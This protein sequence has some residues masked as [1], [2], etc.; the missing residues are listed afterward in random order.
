MGEGRG[1]TTTKTAVKRPPSRIAVREREP[2]QPAIKPRQKTRSLAMRL[3]DEIDA[4][5][6]ELTSAHARLAELET[7]VDEDAL[8]GLLNR[9]GFVKSLE[10]ALAFVRRYRATAA[11]AFLDLDG[12]K[13]VND[14]HGHAAGDWVLGRVGRLIA[15]SVRASDVVARVGGDEFVVLLWNL[16]EAQAAAK[17]RSFEETAEASPFERDGCRYEIGLS[18]GF[19]MLTA[20]DSGDAA[21]ARADAA[22]YA[23]KKERKEKA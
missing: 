13:A 5:K 20:E 21:L 12:F 22:M 2:V 15:G 19:T 10:R 8:T 6:R 3:A 9:R 18:A 1:G 17:A 4:L 16:S 11:L 23:R 7:R 14:R